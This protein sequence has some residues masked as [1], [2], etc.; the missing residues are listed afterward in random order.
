MPICA[1]AENVSDM[2]SQWIL[3][4]EKDG[5][6]DMTALDRLLLAILFG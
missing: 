6:I 4:L 5:G 3:P 2:A 1:V